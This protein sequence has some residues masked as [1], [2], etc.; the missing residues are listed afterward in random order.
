MCYWCALVWRRPV[1]KR[2]LHGS[3]AATEVTGVAP[4]SIWGR[5]LRIK[6]FLVCICPVFFQAGDGIRYRTVTGVQ[7]CALP[8]S[9]VTGQP[10]ARIPASIKLSGTENSFGALG[11]WQLRVEDRAAN[12]QMRIERFAGN[13]EPHDFARAFEDRKSVV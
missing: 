5:Y 7:T 3:S 2:R 8:I 6:R 13:E 12:F 1:K 9:G 4:C 11:H 10:L